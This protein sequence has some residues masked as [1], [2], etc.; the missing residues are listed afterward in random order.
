[1]RE[2]REGGAQSSAT[3]RN[4][5][6]NRGNTR[7]GKGK[8]MRAESCP[9]RESGD[10]HKKAQ[11]GTKIPVFNRAGWNEMSWVLG[12]RRWWPLSLTLSMNLAGADASGILWK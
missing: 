9:I 2:A 10:G 8:I 11:N 3:N 4:R 1:M 5:K 7:K 12:V 6:E